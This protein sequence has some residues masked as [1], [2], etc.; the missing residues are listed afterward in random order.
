M[1]VDIDRLITEVH[2]L[3]ILWNSSNRDYKDRN[4]KEVAWATVAE[5]L[6]ENYTSAEDHEKKIYGKFVFFLNFYFT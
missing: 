3:P 4:K 6:F 5:N 1:E 2:L